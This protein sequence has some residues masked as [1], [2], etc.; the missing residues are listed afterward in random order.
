MKKDRTVCYSEKLTDIYICVMLSVYPLFCLGGYSSITRHKFIFFASVTLAYLALMLLGNAELRLVGRR[1]DLSSGTDRLRSF[2]IIFMTVYIV[3]VLLSFALS[4]HRSA[5]LVGGG[6]YDGLFSE[7]LYFAVL[8][9]VSMFG[10]MRKK[11][12]V[13]LFFVI[14]INFVLVALQL[15]SLNPLGLFPEGLTY[16]DAF[17]KYSGEFLG[18]FGNVDVFSCFFALCVPL[19]LC[20]VIKERR[21]IYFGLGVAALSESVLLLAACRVLAGL[22]GVAASLAVLPFLPCFKLGGKAKKIIAASYLLIG[23]ALAA[24]AVAVFVSS[25]DP[26]MLGSGRLKIWRDALVMFLERPL[27]G[28]GPGTFAE[29][30]SF[31]FERTL[32]SGRVIVSIVDTAHNILLQKLSMTGIFSLAAFLAFVGS[33][34][35]GARKKAPYLVMPVVSYLVLGMFSFEIP[36]VTVFFYILCGLAINKISKKEEV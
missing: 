22:V 35:A 16:Y 19:L 32:T 11:Y 33:V 31:S 13:L 29:N 12:I 23:A 14:S 9:L 36:T 26:L 34:L 28:H 18:T 25:D 8:V 21:G 7:L 10:R 15:M 6:K 5:A 17:E 2:P 30:V 1:T 20:F 27:F 4:E 3:C 24:A